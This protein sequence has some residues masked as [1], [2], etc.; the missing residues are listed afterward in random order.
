MPKEQELKHLPPQN[1]E[2]EQSVLG[3]M[4]I[5]KNAVI[6][7]VDFLRADD[8]YKPAHQKIYQ[9]ILELYNQREPVDILNLTEKLKSK[10]ILKEVGGATYLASLSN[11]VP[12]ASHI[13]SYAKI[14]QQKRLLRDLIS[15]ANDINSLSQQEDRNIDDLLDEAEQ[16]IFQITQQSLSSQQLKDTKEDCISFWERLENKDGRNIRGVTSGYSKLDNYLSGF[17]KSDLIILAARPS[18]GKTSLALNIALNAALKEKTKVGIFSLEMSRDQVVDRLISSSSNVPLWKIRTNKGLTQESLN[19]LHS[20]IDRLSATSIF[21]D[22]AASSNIMRIRAM[23]RRLQADKGLDLLII[24]YLQLIIPRDSKYTSTVQQVTEISRGLKTLAREL[25]IPI[26][27][28][29]QLSRDIEKRDHKKPKLSDL[30]DSGSIEQDADVVMFIHRK[31]R[32]KFDNEVSEEEKNTAEIIIAKHRNGPLGSAM[33]KF[34]QETT[35]FL[36][37][38]DQM[39]GEGEEFPI[40]I[41]SDQELKGDLPF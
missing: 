20:G 16:K 37:I 39:V 28:L 34:N 41:Q 11:L 26:I 38:D 13:I 29:S 30:R 40:N 25:N 17:Q 32:E 4:L 5:D 14:V 10:K 15:T 19:E 36:E 35:T 6:K 2:A 24:D 18:L 3:A 33:L 22:D 8:F 27:A 23:A 21:I 1:I 7:I 12:A 9:S 31:D